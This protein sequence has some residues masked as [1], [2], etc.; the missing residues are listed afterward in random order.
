MKE[1]VTPVRKLNASGSEPKRMHSYSLT[2]V[3]ISNVIFPI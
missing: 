1:L 2:G 3:E